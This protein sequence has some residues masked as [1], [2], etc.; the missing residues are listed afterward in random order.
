[1]EQATDGVSKA[2]DLSNYSFSGFPR[3]VIE[4][5]G[6]DDAISLLGQQAHSDKQEMEV[7]SPIK[8]ITNQM[9]KKEGTSEAT[10][11]GIER[12]T[13]E[14]AQWKRMAREK[15]KNKN[16]GKDAQLLSSGSKRVG[17]LI[18]EEEP[19]APQKKLRLATTENQT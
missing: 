16:P 13:K 12:K 14:T 7:N 1:M 2:H 3:G 8:P 10:G 11:Q 4:N 19:K 18:F 15:G 5:K 9:G 17:K 6:T